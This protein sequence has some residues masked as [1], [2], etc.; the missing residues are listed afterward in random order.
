MELKRIEFI[1]TPITQK[2]ISALWCLKFWP[3]PYNGCII[4][5][6]IFSLCLRHSFL[7]SVLL[8][9][10]RTSP[11]HILQL[12]RLAPADLSPTCLVSFPRLLGTLVGGHMQE[13]WSVFPFMHLIGQKALTGHPLC[14]GHWAT[15]LGYKNDPDTVLAL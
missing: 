8:L 4:I 3:G 6:V 1:R 10:A 12:P 14:V 7:V 2:I 9:T 13:G 15:C 5:S 11:Y